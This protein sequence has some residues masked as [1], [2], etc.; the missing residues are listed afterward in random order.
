MEDKTDLTPRKEQG[1]GQYLGIPLALYALA[2]LGGCAPVASSY[3]PTAQLQ[4]AAQNVSLPTKLIQP[5]SQII[6]TSAGISTGQL[7]SVETNSRLEEI[8]NAYNY[9]I[10]TLQYPNSN[11]SL[12]IKDFA[13]QKPVSELYQDSEHPSLA[14]M[15]VGYDDTF[16][17]GVTVVLDML[18]ELDPETYDG[19]LTHVHVV[20]QAKS[21]GIDT[22][23]GVMYLKDREVVREVKRNGAVVYRVNTE[24][25]KWEAGGFRHE[26]EHRRTSLNGIRFSSS[27]EEELYCNRKE[28]ETL[29]KVFAPKS[30]IDYVRRADGK[31]AD[32]NKD[33]RYTDEDTKL[34]NW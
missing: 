9:N 23:H 15:I 20:H 22:I 14:I 29:Q 4:S 11:A 32:V 3:D 31:H 19:L 16:T 8:T 12:S 10:R 33:G 34:Q 2:H 17:K 25:A 26:L 6:P 21:S 28:V 27:P 24:Q 5:D 1:V 7:N 13:K 18:K 30:M